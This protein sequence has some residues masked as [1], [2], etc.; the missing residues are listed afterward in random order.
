M[1]RRRTA[2]RPEA[3]SLV[4]WYD[5]RAQAA[6]DA[7]V[8]ELRIYGPIGGGWWD[9]PD[10]ITG[11]R[12]ANELA[13]LPES[14]K[15]IRV[16]VSSAGGSVFDAIQ[17]ANA[18]RRERE[19]NKRTV[20]V[21]IEALALSAAT[22]ITSAG[23]QVR[24]ASNAL[25]MVHEPWFLSIGN[26]KQLRKD[27]ELLDRA[28]DAIVA[29]Y[30]WVSSLAVDVLRQLMADETWM[31]AEDALENG[32][33][34]EITGAV[35]AAA[36][37]PAD[38][39]DEMRKRLHVPEQYEERLEQLLKI[40][41]ALAGAD[42]QTDD[43][44]PAPAGNEPEGEMPQPKNPQNVTPTPEPNGQNVDQVK[45]ERDR[46]ISV[47]A[48]VDVGRKIGLDAAKATQLE[49]DAIAQGLSV[50]AV[51]DKVL[52][53]LAAASDA[54][55]PRQGQ[56][57]IVA[58]EDQSEKRRRGIS[59]A[60][61]ARAGLTSIV[62][63][64]ATK[65]PHNPAFAGDLDPGEFRGMSLMDH[66]RAALEEARPGSTRGKTKNEI[67]GDFLRLV[68]AAGQQGT[69]DFPVGLEN[70]LH[71]TLL[72]VYTVTPDTWRRFCGVGS[73]SDF[74][75]HNRYRTGFLG[76]LDTVPESGEF[77]NKSIPDAEKETIT[78]TTKG[79]IVTLSRQAL[80]NDDMGMFNRVATQLGR[81]AALSI[82]SGVYA[83][84]A[85]NAGL[86]PA[87]SDGDTLFHAN[88]GNIGSGAALSVAALD[89]DRVLMK[90]Q[91]D[92]STNDLLDLAPAIL[93]VPAGLEGAALV[94][95][96]A[97]FDVDAGSGKMNRIPNKVRGMVRDVVGT[98]R[99][100]GTRRYLFADPAVMPCI[101]VAFLEGQQAP[102]MEMQEGFRI[103][104]VEWKVRHD[105]GIAAI[106]F[107]GGVTDAGV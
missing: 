94:T 77:P 49:N 52:E 76:S 37:V 4:P 86:G 102:Y 73:V 100:T 43:D 50:E 89:A 12:I 39:R 8:A 14:V 2:R 15:T 72:A 20:L 44:D 104:G 29:T 107:R 88:H 75:A 55:P 51:Q 53:A 21:D 64:A 16:M 36:H 25:F 78:A 38:M 13:A 23:D 19:E 65:D 6:D 83:L 47:K 98:G 26:A 92:S 82:E 33:I 5:L 79:N 54:L 69:S 61:L 91:T 105:F 59:A 80:V 84:L 17:I 9:D 7:T 68:A 41:E 27:A 32:F 93:L 81:A 48:A 62:R 66:A 74:R 35:E 18:L 28:R 101:E 10:A 106:E 97:E 85:Q 99:M 30:R 31:N 46:V 71:K 63:Q 90:T 56:G 45:A 96:N 42:P 58:G 60:L 40:T 103:D 11:K 57:G 67:A 87:M 22:V 3:R 95:I 1:A 34:H 24:M 70:A